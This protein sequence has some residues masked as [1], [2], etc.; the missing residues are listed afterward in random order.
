MTAPDIHRRRAIAEELLQ[1]PIDPNGYARC[2]GAA[3]HTSRNGLRDFRLWIDDRAPAAKCVHD[4]CGNVVAEFLHEWRSRIGKAELQSDGTP[5]PL[6]LAGAVAPL[7]VPTRRPKRPA[8]DPA[9][10][11]RVAALVPE[12]F[13]ADFIAARSPVRVPPVEEQGIETARLVLDTIYA[14]GER[15]L[16]FT[17]QT[18]AGDY[19]HVA[20]KGS[21]RLSRER[22]VDPV[23]SRLPAGAAEGVWFLTNP[24]TG[25]WRI[26]ADGSGW[27]RRTG[28]CITAWKHILLESDAAPDDLWLRCLCALPLRIAAIYSSGGRSL[29]ALVRFSASGKVEW[30]S[31]R[32]VLVDRLGALGA[33]CAA[34][35]A[36]RLSRLAGCL[37]GGKRDRDGRLIRYAKPAL[38][39]LIYLNPNPTGTPLMDALK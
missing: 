30:D 33:D 17:D 26:K 21:F 24:V 2:P 15:V 7:P 20:G 27:S 6:S 28:D 1:S 13:T 34:M 12:Q 23:P 16:V 39:R 25:E 22:G 18:S 11:L 14:A 19:L 32:D 8:Y 29:H 35:S 5:R 4:S 37:R 38:Q 31:M 10:L 3:L 9:A 36:V